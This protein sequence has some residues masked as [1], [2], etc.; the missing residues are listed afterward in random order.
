MKAGFG[1]YGMLM[2]GAAVQTMRHAFARR[3]STHRAWAVRLYALAIG[4]WLYRMDYGFWLLLTDGLSHTRDFRGA[5]DVV[6]AFFFYVPNLLVA[7][8][9]IRWPQLAMPRAA[10][11][12]LA[13][14]LVGASGFILIGTYYFTRYQWGPAI[15]ERLFS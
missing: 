12:T 4:S 3:V 7:E 8:L 2:I 15:L 6:M 9:F 1:R 10:R 14:L 5:F 13:A 11:I